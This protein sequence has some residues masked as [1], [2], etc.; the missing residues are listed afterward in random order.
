MVAPL[1]QPRRPV[2]IKTSIA[3]IDLE[4]VRSLGAAEMRSGLC[5]IGN[6]QVSNICSIVNVLLRDK[7]PPE[8]NSGFQL[9]SKLMQKIFDFL[10]II[11]LKQLHA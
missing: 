10:A 4:G 2:S 7:D 6:L 1:I 8:S 9:V 11:V 3:V 5:S